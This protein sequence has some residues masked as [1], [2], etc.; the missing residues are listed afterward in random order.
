MPSNYSYFS[1]EGYL[2]CL[3]KATGRFVLWCVPYS[4]P[5]GNGGIYSSWLKEQVE[6]VMMHEPKT[7]YLGRSGAAEETQVAWMRIIWDSMPY[8]RP[9][10]RGRKSNSSE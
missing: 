6:S 4:V 7:C 9:V 8:P 5:S 1:Y 10:T 3:S 2:S